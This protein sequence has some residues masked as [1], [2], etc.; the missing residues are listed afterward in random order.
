MAN[1]N[2]RGPIVY[3]AGRVLS[4]ASK[5]SLTITSSCH[6]CVGAVEANK[7]SYK[8]TLSSDNLEASGLKIPQKLEQVTESTSGGLKSKTIYTVGS[9][10]AVGEN[11]KKGGGS[12]TTVGNGYI[13]IL[14]SWE[15]TTNGD[16]DVMVKRSDS[17][18][19]EGTVRM[20]VTLLAFTYTYQDPV[21]P[22]L[23][24][25]G[26]LKVHG[27][28]P[29]AVPIEF[30][31]HAYTVTGSFRVDSGSRSGTYSINVFGGGSESDRKNKRVASVYA[32]GYSSSGFLQGNN[33]NI[34]Q[35][36]SWRLVGNNVEV[37]VGRFQADYS[38]TVQVVVTMIQ[39]KD[40]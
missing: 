33:N 8:F 24:I 26:D 38:D 34:S 17:D 22:L 9:V 21:S 32:R 12:D 31:V 2:V 10:V 30:K 15:V 6:T 11:R 23:H 4:E 20:C 18:S 25:G 13:W 7:T 40:R 14:D 5:P 3:N 27:I 1:L 35:L 16:L 36:T 28:S 19:V 37:N 39:L 29:A